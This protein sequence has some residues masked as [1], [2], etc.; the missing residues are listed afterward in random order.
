MKTLHALLPPTLRAIN[1][2]V[3]FNNEIDRPHWSSGYALNFVTCCLKSYNRPFNTDD[4]GASFGVADEEG[5]PQ[6]SRGFDP[7]QLEIFALGDGSDTKQMIYTV[8][9]VKDR[10]GAV[11]P[12]VVETTRDEVDY[13]CEMV[14]RFLYF[15]HY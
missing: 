5:S 4:W 14:P 15:R 6:V 2:R 1:C 3:T 10:H 11:R 13:V 12:L 8:E 7:R 9:I